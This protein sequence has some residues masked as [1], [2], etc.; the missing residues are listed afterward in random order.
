MLI[1]QGSIEFCHNAK[2]S[3]I[4]FLARLYRNLERKV[5][6]S[7]LSHEK[8]VD[9]DSYWNA[10]R[11]FYFVEVVGAEGFGAWINVKQGRTG[12][13]YLRHWSRKNPP[14]WVADIELD[15]YNETKFQSILKLTK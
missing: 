14:L 3:E 1:L 6:L 11:F 12:R 8:S 7:E 4:S 15:N 13:G 5:W 9:L 2:L 10:K